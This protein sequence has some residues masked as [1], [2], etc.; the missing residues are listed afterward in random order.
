M[1]SAFSQ[2]LF[3]VF[4]SQKNVRKKY[5]PKL[6]PILQKA[7]HIINIELNSWKL[8]NETEICRKKISFKQYDL[9]GSNFALYEKLKYVLGA[10]GNY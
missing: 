7:N 8:N 10:K 5:S 9:C 4:L 1:E 6:R 3:S 2:R